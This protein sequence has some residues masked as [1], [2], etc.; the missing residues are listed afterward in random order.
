MLL[1]EFVEVVPSPKKLE[2]KSGFGRFLAK[3]RFGYPLSIL[4]LAFGPNLE[5][6]TY[7]V[8]YQSCSVMDTPDTPRVPMGNF[9]Y[10]LLLATIC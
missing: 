2:T 5:M 8:P 10:F 6:F 1:E 4:V 9:N 7:L 3:T